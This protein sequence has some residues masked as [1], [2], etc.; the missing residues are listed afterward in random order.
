MSS[1]TQIFKLQVLDNPLRGLVTGLFW[2]FLLTKI[3]CCGS[4]VQSPVSVKGI[5]KH[6]A[7]CP[8][9]LHTVRPSNKSFARKSSHLESVNKN[10]MTYGTSQGHGENFLDFGELWLWPSIPIR[11]VA[12][13]KIPQLFLLLRDLLLPP[14]LYAWSVA[15]VEIKGAIPSDFQ[16]KSRMDF[17]WERI[18]HIKRIFTPD[19]S[20][21]A[22]FSPLLKTVT[23]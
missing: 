5:C 1:D 16:G 6:A 11:G 14:W 21:S 8:S 9:L 7:A 4:S 17:T 12:C 22:F 20:H 2:G 13:E 10:H 23:R 3:M 18:P 19:F 15:V